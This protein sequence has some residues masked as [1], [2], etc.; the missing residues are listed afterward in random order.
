MGLFVWEWHF[1]APAQVLEIYY[2]GKLIRIVEAHR[3][4]L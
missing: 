3:L 1:I 2:F 4:S